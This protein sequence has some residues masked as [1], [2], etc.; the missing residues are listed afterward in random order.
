MFMLIQGVVFFALLFFC[1]S[2][3]ARRL[4]QAAVTGTVTAQKDKESDEVSM[5][6]VSQV[7]SFGSLR[8]ETI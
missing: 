6:R 1:E 4:L 8:T 5:K 3:T 7:F 2:G